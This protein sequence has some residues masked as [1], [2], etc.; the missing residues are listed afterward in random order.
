MLGFLLCI[1]SMGCFIQLGNKPLGFLLFF[2]SMLAFVIA[3]RDHLNQSRARLL[4]SIWRGKREKNAPRL[5]L[6]NG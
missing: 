6:K 4:P 2:G 1:F 5:E 3:I